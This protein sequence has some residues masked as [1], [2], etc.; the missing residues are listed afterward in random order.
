MFS[1]GVSLYASHLPMFHT[2]HDV[3][4]IARIKLQDQSTHK[5]LIQALMSN[6]GY[7]TLAP[8]RFD[9]NRLSSEAPERLRH[10][11][12]NL[13]SGHFE[14]EGKQHFSDRVIEI[15]SVV[16]HQSLSRKTTRKAEFIRIT[17]NSVERQFYAR[18]IRG[19]PGV[20]QLFW[21]ESTA[22]LP[23]SFSIESNSLT[24][25]AKTI[26]EMLGVVPERLH[27]Y[28]EELGDLQ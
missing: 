28:Y 15:Q 20:D 12:A 26:A 7:W 1:D 16:V 24:F 10:F 2:P 21:L 6:A 11:N 19:K 18:I 23:K 9:L 25:N 27:L 3:Q 17:P 22:Q 14:R 4:F 5:A 13:F 8:Q